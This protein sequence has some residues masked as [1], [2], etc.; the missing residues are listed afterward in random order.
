MKTDKDESSQNPYGAPL[1][2]EDAPVPGP[3]LTWWQRIVSSLNILAKGLAY[4]ML[5]F[6]GS[7]FAG[8]LIILFDEFV[9]PGKDHFDRG[10]I[11]IGSAW[12][13]VGLGLVVV[14]IYVIYMLKNHLGRSDG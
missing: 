9:L 10:Y 5:T 14:P 8:G 2:I 3:R 4:G 7:V 13:G 6:I 1:T 11:G 12:L